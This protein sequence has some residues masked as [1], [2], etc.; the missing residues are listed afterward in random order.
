MKLE[1]LQLNAA[2]Y[3]TETEFAPEHPSLRAEYALGA[4]KHHTHG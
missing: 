4:S 3:G 1:Q 2:T